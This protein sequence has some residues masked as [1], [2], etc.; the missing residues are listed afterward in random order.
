AVRRG[1]A[2]RMAGRSA[3]RAGARDP[4]LGRV[5]PRASG[6]RRLPD[7]PVGPDRRRA[8][9]RLSYWFRCA[10]FATP[11]FERPLPQVDESNETVSASTAKSDAVAT[12]V[13]RFHVTLSGEVSQITD[14]FDS[15]TRQYWCAV[16]EYVS[17]ARSHSTP[18]T[19]VKA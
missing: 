9:G 18:L 4:R 5:P 15:R 11:G 2:P 12:L 6:A 1:G 7:P 13:A 17:V 8:R 16:A 19:K 14:P 10:Y 3:R